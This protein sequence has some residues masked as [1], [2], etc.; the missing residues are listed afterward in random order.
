MIILQFSFVKRVVEIFEV[1]VRIVCRSQRHERSFIPS[2]TSTVEV[3]TKLKTY[4]NAHM[5]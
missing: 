4:L 2:V 1:S 3:I 5:V